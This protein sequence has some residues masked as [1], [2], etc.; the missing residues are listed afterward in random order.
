MSKMR[1]H[2]LAKELDIKSS[3]I[4]EVLGEKGIDVK[5]QSSIDEASIEIVKKKFPSAKS[6]NK[7]EEKAKPRVLITSKGV[8]KTGER[9]RRR[10]SSDGEHK[11]R[12]KHS[13]EVKEEVKENVKPNET[14]EKAVEE[15]T[16]P[17]DTTVQAKETTPKAEEK[18]PVEVKEVAKEVVKEPVKEPVKEV[19]NIENKIQE[20]NTTEKM[21]Q[22]ETKPADN[23]QQP[24]E[25][26]PKKK[27]GL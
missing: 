16:A 19:E 2:E 5:A 27:K 23:K 15:K 18:K 3:D 26:Y 20:E 7:K 21:A 4:I 24:K 10:H 14:V 6:E 8:V 12:S 17:K 9:R 13:S 1:V 22:R 11:H 25:I